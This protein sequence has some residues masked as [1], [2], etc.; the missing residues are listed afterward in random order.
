MVKMKKIIRRIESIPKDISYLETFFDEYNKLGIIGLVEGKLLKNK[1]I[2]RSRI[3]C[4]NDS[5]TSLNKISYQP[6]SS[7]YFGRANC[8]G[9]IMF[10]G[11]YTPSLAGNEQIKEAYLINAYEISSFLRDDNSIGNMKIT[12]GKWKVIE[13]INIAA[14]IFHPKFKNKTLFVEDLNNRF[15]AFLKSNPHFARNT[16]IWNKFISK[17]FAK[18]VEEKLDRNYIISASFSQHLIG[19]GF[20]G[21]VYPTVKL[22]G[23][24][25]NIALT[26]ETVDKKLKL[27]I[28]AEGRFYKHKKRT[29]LDWEK[30][31][32]VDKLNNFR[33]LDSPE[34]LG[35]TFCLDYLKSS[36]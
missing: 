5:Y 1:S 26:K 20:E 16:K 8:P 24:G 3:N 22:D 18:E 21:I 2:Y 12:I 7:K 6:K 23:K 14:I 30:K 34:K 27:D 31:C 36:K 35:A 17:E 28:V 9:N 33:F 13:D 19:K 15:N 4:N 10:Y 11:S 29:I 32:D 25:L